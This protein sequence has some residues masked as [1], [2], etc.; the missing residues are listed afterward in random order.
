VPTKKYSPPLAGL[1]TGLSMATKSLEPSLM[2]RSAIDQG[3]IMAGSFTTGFIAGS[4]SAVVLDILPPFGGTS[5]LRI[6]GVVATGVRAASFVQGFGQSPP[7]STSPATA[8]TEAGTDLMSGVALSGVPDS[9]APALGAVSAIA[10]TASMVHDVQA[11]L[12]VRDDQPD[13]KYL[14]TATGVALGA[15]AGVGA[16][17]ALV[18]SS[19]HLARKMTRTHGLI[20]TFMYATGVV[21]SVGVLGIGAKVG[22]AR[23]IGSIGKGNQTFEIRYQAAPDGANVTGGA[24]S[25]VPYDT[26][27]LQGRRLVSVATTADDIETVMGESP[28]KDPVRVFIGVDSAESIEER[29]ELAIQELR[30]TGGFDRCE[31]HH[32]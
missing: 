8:W 3:L 20:G 15:V 11:A 1:L 29:V 28:R 16:L 17:A 27:G 6:A 4:A 2:P 9:N 30:R 14:A 7:A 26:L 19:G 31:L 23:V 32:R 12:H 25:L 10:V 22:G 5:A 18:H 13:A 24:Y 21:A